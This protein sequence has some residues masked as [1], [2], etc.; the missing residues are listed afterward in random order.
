L[1]GT[2]IPDYFGPFV[3]C[4]EFKFYSIGP[5]LLVGEEGAGDD[6]EGHVQEVEDGRDL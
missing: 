2:Y 6:G 5:W 1:P 3:S 4:E